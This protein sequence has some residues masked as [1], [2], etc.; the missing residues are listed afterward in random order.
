MMVGRSQGNGIDCLDQSLNA[1]TYWVTI[2]GGS[3]NLP[4]DLP[5]GML[6]VL[7]GTTR[8]FVDY[9][10]HHVYVNTYVNNTWQGWRRTIMQSDF[11]TL[12]VQCTM[13]KGTISGVSSEA[14]LTNTL[15]NFFSVLGNNNKSFHV[16]SIYVEGLTFCGG[17]WDVFTSRTTVDYGYQ[18]VIGYNGVTKKRNRT[19]GSWSSWKD[20]INS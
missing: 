7:S 15:H 10:S 8:F 13:D 18:I 12:Y 6:I 5:Y 4:G 1:G 19:K 20:F 17:Q 16:L 3:S 14:E 9:Y 11:S 2:G